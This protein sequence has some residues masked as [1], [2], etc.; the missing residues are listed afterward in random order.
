MEKAFLISVYLL[1][2]KLNIYCF[3]RKAKQ[4]CLAKKTIRNTEY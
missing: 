2:L 1:R 3:H 4:N